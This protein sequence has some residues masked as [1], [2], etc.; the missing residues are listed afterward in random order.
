MLA[1]AGFDIELLQQALNE[2]EAAARAA[3]AANLTNFM[4]VSPLSMA[5]RQGRD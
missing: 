2:S 5:G 1:G 3:M 4:N